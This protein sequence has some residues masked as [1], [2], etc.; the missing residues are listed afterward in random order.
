M[1]I[2]HQT[3]VLD[4]D[5]G[6]SFLNVTEREN[7]AKSLC[8][9]VSASSFNHLDENSL[10]KVI[11]EWDEEELKDIVEHDLE[12]KTVQVQTLAMCDLAEALNI[13]EVPV[14]AGDLV[15]PRYLSPRDLCLVN[16]IDKMAIQED[17]TADHGDDKNGHET[18]EDEDSIKIVHPTSEFN[19]NG[20]R[21]KSVADLKN[22]FESFSEDPSVEDLDEKFDAFFDNVND[23]LNEENPLSSFVLKTPSKSQPH[24][25]ETKSPIKMVLDM[26]TPPPDADMDEEESNVP[27]AEDKIKLKN[28]SENSAKK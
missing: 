27:A 2:F 18:A 15:S 6:V 11:N 20:K 16:G 23:N 24:L 25:M 8:Q 19:D 5:C 17:A 10:K 1:G 22:M 7:I 14:E 28:K 3:E 4:D 9:Q 21:R 26:I 13:E 12:T